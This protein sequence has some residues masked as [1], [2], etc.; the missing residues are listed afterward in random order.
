MDSNTGVSTMKNNGSH[1]S[2]IIEAEKKTIQES[3]RELKEEIAL[4]Q[5]T[6]NLAVEMLDNLYSDYRK[7]DTSFAD[8]AL[9][10]ILSKIIMSLKSYFDLVIKGYYHEATVIERN[11]LESVLLCNLIAEK[12]EYAVK[13]LKGELRSWDVR[14]ALRLK[15]EGDLQE[16]YKMMSD[17]V[18]TNV[19]SLGLIIQ[20]EIEKKRMAV[21]WAP[22]F[23]KELAR[24]MLIP[25]IGFILVSHFSD[26]FKDE[27]DKSFLDKIA[28]YTARTMKI[29]E[30]F[31]IS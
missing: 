14:K 31:S 6:L 1:L 8:F 12:E 16:I 7:K 19:C 24:H 27:L 17:Y 13:W 3:S 20:F 23:D 11:I 21:R 29:F 2:Y 15:D 5:E 18:H 28:K 4:Y 25:T 26:V 9:L 22:K 10:P 30:K